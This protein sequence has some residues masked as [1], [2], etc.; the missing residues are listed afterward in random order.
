METRVPAHIEVSG[1]LR[2]AQA[3]GDF[4]MVLHKGE[5]D[6]GTIL[7]VMLDNQG[8]GSLFERMPQLDGTRKWTQIKSQVYDNKQE[9]EDY[10]SR[11]IAQ[12]PDVWIVELTVAKAEQFIRD[13]LSPS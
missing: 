8:L 12:D 1:L 13:N 2:T 10:L 3:G 7:V 5:R 6:A 11:R 9:F 4:G